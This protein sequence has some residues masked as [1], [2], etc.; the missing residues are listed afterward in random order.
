MRAHVW[1][2][3]G[4]LAAPGPATSRYGGNTSCIE[5]R[6]DGAPVVILDAGTGMRALGDALHR[7]RDREIHVL[8]S[9]LHLDHIQGL[10]FFRPLY[11]PEVQL[12]V[13]GPP[14]PTHDLR[15]RIGAY[16][17]EPL[18]PVNITDVPCDA[19]FHDAPESAVVLGPVSMWS[20]PVAHQGPTVG[21]RLES[22]G[23]SLVYLPDH[24]PVLGRFSHGVAHHSP[25]LDA[26]PAWVSG[27]ALAD[28][29]D[30]LFHDSQYFADE[31]ERRVGWGHSAV[32]DTVA[33]A[34]ICGARRLVLFHHDPAHDDERLDAKFDYA[35]A[36]CS[37]RG[38]PRPL[39]ARDGMELA[40]GAPQPS[41]S[42]SGRPSL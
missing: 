11:D 40:V 28:G 25:L 26:D 7:A 34:E 39:I 6:A 9:H 3:R 8:L 21:Y 38:L 19:H 37:A 36:L 31:Y 12:H 4:S 42:A 1:G 13:W 15:E 33:F 16:M 18:F 14:S 5:I 27:H 35:V 2:S 32:D 10:A 29:A 30:V 22:D 41:P 24:E 17:S 20:A 23:A